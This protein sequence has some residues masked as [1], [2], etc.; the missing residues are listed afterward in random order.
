M[1]T[2]PVVTVGLPVYNARST[3]YSAVKSVLAQSFQNWELIVVDDGST[4]GSLNTLEA[5]D[6]PR[7]RIVRNADNRGLSYRLNQIADVARG[8]FVARFDADDLL[9]PE[10]L[11]RQVHYL[12]TNTEI[13]V[14]GTAAYM[15]S[16]EGKIIGARYS[17]RL[18]RTVKEVLRRGLLLHPTIM[19]RRKWFL[20]N[21]YD[22]NLR[23]AQDRDLWCR[24]VE[25]SVFAVINEPLYFYRERGAVTA[26][27]YL[28]KYLGSRDVRL[29]LLRRYG[30]AY[31]N[32]FE[33]LMEAASVIA[34]GEVYRLVV[35][36][37][38]LDKLF[39]RRGVEISKE[40]CSEAEGIIRKIHEVELT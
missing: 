22:P 23:R 17:S 26:D 6:D 34:K 33:R 10:R 1:D 11:Q 39:A 5:I 9:H 8:E 28:R 38:F 31:M 20:D 30:P 24:T 3:L 15:V 4:D 40:E 19:A 12:K 32:R 7:V 36:C 37:G 2:N 25:T 14:V 35:K 27:A 29:Q 13:D 21:G 18:P 16:P